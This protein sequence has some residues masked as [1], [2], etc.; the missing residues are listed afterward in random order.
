M[1]ATTDQELGEIERL[2]EEVER[3][4]AVNEA[5]RSEV[6]AGIGDVMTAIRGREWLRLGRGSYEWD[7]DR[8]KDEFGAALDEIVEALDRLKKIATDKTDCPTTSL[9]VA[10]AR[11]RMRRLEAENDR[12]R[13]LI[14]RPSVA[15]WRDAVILEA[16]HQ[17]ERWGAD[18]DARHG[19]DGW[20]WRLGYLSGKALAAHLAGDVEKALHH[21][22]SSGA[23]L[24]HWAEAMK[25]GAQ[26]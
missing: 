25:K 22:V 10:Q 6:A 3:L 12:L 14:D 11:D 8:W 16:A 23:L 2:K 19:P 24:A 13:D 18:H 15:E 7:D 1:S 20:F 4:H 26:S 9:G 5:D 17:R 21:T